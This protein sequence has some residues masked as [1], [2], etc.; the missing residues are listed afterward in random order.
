M[1]YNYE[2]MI[3]SAI[4]RRI[5]PEGKEDALASMTEEEKRI[6]DEKAEGLETIFTSELYE[7]TAEKRSTY[8][9]AEVQVIPITTRER[10]F[11]YFGFLPD[12]AKSFNDYRKNYNARSDGL[13]I[14]PTWK[15]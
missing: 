4:R 6:W 10:E 8:P 2:T 7:E 13:R 5:H 14:K 1:C 11:Y 15:K 12:W 9:G 3:R